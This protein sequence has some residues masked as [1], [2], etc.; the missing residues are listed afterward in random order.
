MLHTA[1]VPLGNDHKAIKALEDSITRG[2]G[3]GGTSEE[4]E[5]SGFFIFI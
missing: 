4:W 3:G 5:E 2:G 1:H